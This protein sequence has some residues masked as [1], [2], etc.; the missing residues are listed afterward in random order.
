MS[1]NS[2]P[3]RRIITNLTADTLTVYAGV[4]SIEGLPNFE[5]ADVERCWRTCPAVCV[6]QETSVEVVIPTAPCDCPYQWQIEIKGKPCL[7]MYRVSETFPTSELYGYNSP[8]GTTP[9]DT[10]VA[11]AIADQINSNP[12]SIVTAVATGDDI[13]LTEKDCDSDHGSCGFSV[14]VLSGVITE[15]TPHTDAI[16]KPADL[17]RVFPI[18]HGDFGTT[19]IPVNCGTYCKYYLYVMAPDRIRDAHIDHAWNDRDIEIEI[20]VDSAASNFAAD[21][22][23]PLAAALDC[24]EPIA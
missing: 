11:T 5:V 22:D 19:P 21:W 16:L 1:L 18:G 8:D 24:L 9:T 15:V 3:T 14:H 7:G 6:P 4:I 2:L 17:R 10:A 12:N 23:T 20:W 13:V